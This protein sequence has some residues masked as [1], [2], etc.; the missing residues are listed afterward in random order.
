MLAT[1]SLTCFSPR[2][3]A[4]RESLEKRSVSEALS[5]MWEML[6]VS[7]SIAAAMLCVDSAWLVAASATALLDRRICWEAEVMLSAP[8]HISA[9][10]LRRERIS[11]LSSASKLSLALALSSTV[12][13]PPAT[14]FM[15]R[16]ACAGS[17]PSWPRTDWE[18]SKITPNTAAERRRMTT[19][20]ISR[21]CRNAISISSTYKPAPM[22]QFQPSILAA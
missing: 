6:T 21:L 11:E 10:R 16:M 4:S 13:S 3:A 9:I 5:D 15:I 17:P 20:K 12:R 18:M 1:A 7:S 22:T 2:L 14:C 19:P 8:E